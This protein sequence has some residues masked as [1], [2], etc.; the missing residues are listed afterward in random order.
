MLPNEF[1]LNENLF[2]A[3]PDAQYDFTEDRVSSAAFKDSLGASVDR[4]GGRSIEECKNLILSREKFKNSKAIVH[5]TVEYCRSHGGEPHYDPVPDNSFH[6]IITRPDG[7]A[8]LT[9]GTAKRLREGNV[10]YKRES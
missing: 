5:F 2:R 9:R 6:S 8:H 10:C 1:D 3:V 7:T 4:Q